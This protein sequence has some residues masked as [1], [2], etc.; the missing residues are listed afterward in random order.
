MTE[1]QNI[2][3]TDEDFALLMKGLDAL[4]SANLAGEL[5]IDMMK[6]MT[7]EAKDEEGRR[8]ILEDRK[9]DRRKDE[10]AKIEL[11]ESILILQAKLLLLKRYLRSQ[12]AFKEANDIIHPK[13]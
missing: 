8:K 12:G 9:R 10:L 4:P 7:T 3:L 5:M 2:D 1:L 6:A 11:Q 13:T